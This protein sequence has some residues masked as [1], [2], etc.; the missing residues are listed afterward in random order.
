MT[1]MR[2][3]KEE[4]LKALAELH[5]FNEESSYQKNLGII[6]EYIQDIVT[7]MQEYK[8]LSDMSIKTLANLT[9]KLD[10]LKKIVP[11]DH[12]KKGQ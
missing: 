1:K 12:K 6:D 10:A 8:K 5:T 2:H 7:S 3:E 4:V 9:A 11:Q